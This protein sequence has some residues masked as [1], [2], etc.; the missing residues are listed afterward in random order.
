MLFRPTALRTA[1]MAPP[2]RRWTFSGTHWLTSPGGAG[3]T[4]TASTNGPARLIFPSATMGS[5]SFAAWVY[6]MGGGS[7]QG[8]QF[9]TIPGYNPGLVIY[10][11]GNYQVDLTN[12]AGAIVGNIAG[13]VPVAATWE[14]LAV[15]C[16]GT[17]MRVYVNGA[18]QAGSFA[19]AATYAAANSSLLIAA[20]S[21]GRIRS[22][23]LWDRT[24]SLDEVASLAL[25]APITHDLREPYVDYLGGA[26]PTGPV[27]W[28][29]ADG[30]GGTVV[31]NRGS[32][33]TCSLTLAGSV[34]IG[35]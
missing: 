32:G 15:T 14:H 13:A 33:G 7:G 18:L 31:T 19:V 20:G 6:D 29:P 25:D 2:A 17:T 1:V 30:D 24:L 21:S 35:S 9:G 26:T 5:W 27:Y 28:W 12:A 8:P 16:D 34:T 23:A 4:A 3:D 22:P 11:D 10:Q